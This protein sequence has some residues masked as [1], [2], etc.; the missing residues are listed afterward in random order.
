MKMFISLELRGIFC[1]NFVYYCILTL[2]SR[3]YAKRWWDFTKHHF[4]RSSSFGENAH[5]S[6]TMRCIWF[7]LCILMYFNI[8][9]P[10]WWR[11]FT[12]HHLA[13]RAVLVKM[14][15][16][17]GQHG[18]FCFDFVYLCILNIAQPLMCKMLTRLHRASFCRSSSFNENAHILLNFCILL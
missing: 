16:T 15:I 18:I 3:W 9:Q 10:K 13:D 14:L 8:V 7:K 1:S 4:G 6:W 17:L 12:E 2:S 11:G 5:T